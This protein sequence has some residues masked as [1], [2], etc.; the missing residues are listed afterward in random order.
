[1]QYLA[2]TMQFLIG[3]LLFHE[4]FDRDRAIGFALIWVALAVFMVDSL[5][6]ARAAQAT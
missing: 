6:R 5:R 2:P 1:M 4:P 3:V